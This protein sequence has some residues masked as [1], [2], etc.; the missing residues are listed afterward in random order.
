MGVIDIDLLNKSISL[1]F[2]K[3]WDHFASANKGVCIVF[4]T[5]VDFTL[6][7]GEIRFKR[8]SFGFVYHLNVNGVVAKALR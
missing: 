8:I 7:H 2:S 4:V 3:E 1:L 6:I 5:E